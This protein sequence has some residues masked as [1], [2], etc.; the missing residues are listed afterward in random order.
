VI[1]YA[2]SGWLAGPN[3]G[4]PDAAAELMWGL[5]ESGARRGDYAHC[6]GGGDDDC[7]PPPQPTGYSVRSQVHVAPQGLPGGTMVPR[8]TR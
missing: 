8:G 6:E 3:A 5:A 1:V 4:V 7:Y 2:A